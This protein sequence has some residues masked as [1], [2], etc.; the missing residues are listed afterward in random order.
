VGVGVDVLVLVGEGV[1]VLVIVGFASSVRA[2]ENAISASESPQAERNTPIDRA[3][4]M[5]DGNI[6]I[7]K[8]TLLE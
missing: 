2:L 1:I 3:T 4:N 8:T 6:F 7:L 5:N